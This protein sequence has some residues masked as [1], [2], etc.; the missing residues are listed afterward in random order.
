MKMA[1]VLFVAMLAVPRV[2]ATTFEIDPVHSSVGFRVA[3]LVISKVSG[4]FAKYSG[5]VVY[6]KGS[7]KTWSAHATIDT[8][9]VDTGNEQRDKHLRS[10]DFLDVDKYPTIEFKSVRAE[11]KGGKTKLIGDLTLHGVTKRIALDLTVNGTVKDPFGDGQ[12]LGA[13]GTA[14]INRK[15]Y[16][17][18]WNKALE[19]GGVMVGDEVEL[20]LDIEGVAKKA[21]VSKP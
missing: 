13:V 2:G 7:P 14:V 18:T 9:S 19:T 8:T 4:K 1:L 15:D 5:T 20:T 17:L 6:E 10:A 16:G 3:H 11:N 21:E 12:R